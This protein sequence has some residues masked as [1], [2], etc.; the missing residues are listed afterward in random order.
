MAVQLQMEVVV[1]CQASAKFVRDITAVLSQVNVHLQAVFAFEALGT[2]LHAPSLTVDTAVVMLGGGEDVRTAE[3]KALLGWRRGDIFAYLRKSSGC[4]RSFLLFAALRGVSY[5]E[6]QI[7]EVM[8][9]MLVSAGLFDKFP[10]AAQQLRRLLEVL[11]PKARVF[12]EDI[13]C[14]QMRVL[15]IAACRPYDD[16]G[17]LQAAIAHLPPSTMGNLLMHA[18]ETVRLDRKAGDI[19]ELRGATGLFDVATVL[20]WLAPEKT[21]LYLR[22]KNSDAHLMYRQPDLGIIESPLLIQSGSD[23]FDYDDKGN[24]TSGWK[25]VPWSSAKTFALDALNWASIARPLIRGNSGIL[26]DVAVN[27]ARRWMT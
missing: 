18:F 16:Q 23:S 21:A 15:S 1:A 3:L 12:L 11:E 8:C 22:S 10:T 24:P 5:D 19:I 4:V 17:D 20:F 7:S 27:A 6:S 26:G 2:C 14:S 13:A 25:K 9:Q